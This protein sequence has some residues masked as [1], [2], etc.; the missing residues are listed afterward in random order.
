MG[1]DQQTTA[2]SPW[3]IWYAL[4][5]GATFVEVCFVFGFSEVTAIAA[6]I[7]IV[8]AILNAVIDPH[9]RSGTA[10]GWHKVF[11][12]TRFSKVACVLVWL[13]FVG[14]AV[15]AFRDR[16]LKAF[17][18]HGQVFADTGESATD[19]AV[20]LSFGRTR[21]TTTCKQGVFSFGGLHLPKTVL[22]IVD[23]TWKNKWGRVVVD[24]SKEPANIVVTVAPRT[25]PLRFS[26]ITLIANGIDYFLQGTIDKAWDPKIGGSPYIVP[27]PA[28]SYLRMLASRFS[29]PRP[30]L[31]GMFLKVTNTSGKDTEIKLSP[32]SS[33]PQL[34]GTSYYMGDYGEAIA[35]DQAFPLSDDNRGEWWLHLRGGPE[36][37]APTIERLL[38]WRFVSAEDLAQFAH[39]SPN[40]PALGFLSYLMERKPPPDLALLSM[41]IEQ[42]P[43]G[44]FELRF[45]PRFFRVRI[46]VIEN[47]AAH[48]VKIDWIGLRE[49]PS[50]A[51]RRREQDHA[52][53]RVLPLNKDTRF[54]GE[55]LTSGERIIVPIELIMSFDAD[56]ARALIGRPLTSDERARTESEFQAV[57]MKYTDDRLT[58]GSYVLPHERFSELLAR[59]PPRLELK[60]EY[61]FG[62]STLL[63]SVGVDDQIIAARLFKPEHFLI[64]NNNESGSCPYLYVSDETGAWIRQRHLLYGHNSKAKETTDEV[65]LHGF[66][67]NVR[68]QEDEDEISYI[69]SVSLRVVAV[70]RSSSVVFPVV[71]GSVEH[72]GSYLVLRKGQAVDFTASVAAGARV[73]IRVHGYY[74]NS[75]RSHWPP[76]ES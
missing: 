15:H 18:L 11:Q 50:D 46:A 20:E 14:L 23:A 55:Y 62:P 21:L 61:L 75:S 30:K 73:F 41:D 40:N 56:L 51:F 54:P 44:V 60:S 76:G 39:R 25:V 9:G 34:A 67:G 63:D 16:G 33:F 2:T 36:S 26:Y 64:V 47:I 58:E 45:T 27:T 3:Q 70:D 10:H 32:G 5:V 53:L 68:I 24:P 35:R 12:V 19:A 29:Q 69:D 37:T 66:H 74:L 42:C 38:F 7:G 13:F 1:S 49:N 65:E 71:H 8:V 52:R 59:T 17:D 4:G 72:Q 22:V 6:A 43:N 48:P 31:D 57:T 28:F